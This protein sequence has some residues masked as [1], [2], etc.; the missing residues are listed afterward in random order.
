[1]DIFKELINALAPSLKQVGFNK[2]GNSFYLES[3]KNYGV[4][5]F[6]KSRDCTREVIKFTINF[7]V[8]SNVLA[9]NA[10]YYNNS[11]KPEVELCHWL[12]R[13]GDFM[14]GSPD[15]WWIINISDD[16]SRITSNVMETIRSIVMPEINKHLSDEDLIK[17]WM[18]DSCYS[19]T[20]DFCRFTYLTTLL[21]AK[22]DLDTIK[23]VIETFKH[24]PEWKQYARSA[25]EHLKEIEYSK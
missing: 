25:L 13:V 22:D 20:T 19:G 14:L 7:G 23:Q 8:Y 6:Q 24:Y 5:N 1:M 10:W 16:L 9:K 15:F 21:K 17:C 12:A 2:K 18:N 11:A 4:I 3:G